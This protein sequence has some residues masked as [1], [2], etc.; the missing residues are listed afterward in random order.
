MKVGDGL[1]KGIGRVIAQQR[2][3]TAEGLAAGVKVAGAAGRV[4]GNQLVLEAIGTP[5]ALRTVVIKLAV[6]GADEGQRLLVGVAAL[7]HNF[8]F[9]ILGYAE[10]VFHQPL[11]IGEN[12]G[13]H[14]LENILAALLGGYQNRVV[15]MAAA[16]GLGVVQR[17]VEIKGGDHIF[18][19]LGHSYASQSFSG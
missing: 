6:G 5:G 2:L 17:A 18:E 12:V 1:A 19:L 16:E 11:G 8:L 10:Y 3:K 4:Q 7:L 13:V 9:Q 15:D 14:F